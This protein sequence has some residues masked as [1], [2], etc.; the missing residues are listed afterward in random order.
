MKRWIQLIGKITLA[1]VVASPLAADEPQSKADRLAAI[2]ARRHAIPLGGD[3]Q[4][5]PKIPVVVAVAHGMRIVLSRDDGRTWRQVFFGYPSG[6]HSS[7]ATFDM[8]YT[9]G[10]F[11][12]FGG[13]GAAGR[14]SFIASEDG[15]NWRHLSGPNRNGRYDPQGMD[16][17][18]GGAA[19]NETIMAV[20]TGFQITPDFGKSWDKV[21]PSRFEPPVASHHQKAVF[22]D[23]DGGRFV[24]VGDA[25]FAFVSRDNGRNWTTSRI[26]PDPPADA[27]RGLSRDLAY[28]N[29]IF[30]VADD[31]GRLVHRSTD[32][33][34]TWSSHEHGVD[35]PT[36]AFS[37]LS[38]V[39]GEFWLTGKTP[40]ASRDGMTWREL[41]TTTPAGKVIETDR[42]TLI[43]VHRNRPEILR[44][45]DGRTWEQVY[46]LTAD[47]M[48]VPGG[49][50]GFVRA[51][52]GYVNEKPVR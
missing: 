49:A 26:K 1:L 52:F 12:G 3:Y 10:V 7:W 8:A 51:L 17:A 28:G 18:W 45:T 50:Q 11:V 27:P 32:G 46:A 15:L 20:G 39:Q 2:D 19:G 4:P 34:Q 14:G 24:V 21:S 40:R 42:G 30:L 9:G 5:Q 43:S 16:D 13:W 23:F 22:G 29:G 35:R 36:G 41:P 48:R 44:S 25:P 37:S 38:F 33:G 31:Q 47:D 6:D